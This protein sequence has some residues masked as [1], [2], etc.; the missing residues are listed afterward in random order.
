MS[1]KIASKVVVPKKRPACQELTERDEEKRPKMGVS[2]DKLSV[3][4]EHQK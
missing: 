4:K 1:S 3:G 2:A